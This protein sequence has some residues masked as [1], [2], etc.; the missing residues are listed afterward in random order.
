M[1]KKLRWCILTRPIPWGSLKL[2]THAVLETD[3]KA[4]WLHYWKHC[5][6]K[7]LQLEQ[8]LSYVWISGR[9]WIGLANRVPGFVHKSNIIIIIFIFFNLRPFWVRPLIGLFSIPGRLMLTWTVDKV[10]ISLTR[11]NTPL[12]E[13]ASQTSVAL[14]TNHNLERSYLW[15]NIQKN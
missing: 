3:K 10:H 1:Y 7:R 2:W 4:D 13:K 12:K 14:F 9:S 5:E 11:T 6:K 8:K 15:L